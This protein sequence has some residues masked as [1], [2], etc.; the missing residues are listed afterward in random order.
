MECPLVR[1]SDVLTKEAI[2]APTGSWVKS[3]N[4][5]YFVG[6]MTETAYSFLDFYSNYWK[7]TRCFFGGGDQDL[8]GFNPGDGLK[9]PGLAYCSAGLI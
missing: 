6:A 8:V 7:R 1:N 5:S 2:T 4:L 9:C 3:L